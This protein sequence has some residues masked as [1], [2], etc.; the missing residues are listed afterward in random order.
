MAVGDMHM[1]PFIGMDRETASFPILQGEVPPHAIHR[2]VLFVLISH[3]RIDR[4]VLGNHHL[5]PSI[6][7]GSERDIRS[8]RNMTDLRDRQLL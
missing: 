4:A 2:A 5:R 3:H 1:A 8:F 6:H 7:I